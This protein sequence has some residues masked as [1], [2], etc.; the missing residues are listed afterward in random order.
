MF[1]VSDESWE[2]SPEAKS[3]LCIL[4]LAKLTINYI[5]NFLKNALIRL[6]ERNQL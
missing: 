4:Y 6:V 3:T 2:C 5:K 1:Y